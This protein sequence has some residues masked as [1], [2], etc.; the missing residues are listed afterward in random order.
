MA[1]QQEGPTDPQ[2]LE[3][4]VDQF[5]AEQMEVSHSPGAVFV[6][7]KD[8]EIFLAKGYGYADLENQRPF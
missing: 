2:E 4:F 1:P 8:G 6:L 5:F 7:V 3:A